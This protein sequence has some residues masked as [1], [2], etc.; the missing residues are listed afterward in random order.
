ML[1][2]LS[3]TTSKGGK[4]LFKGVERDHHSDII[5]IETL[6]K[7]VLNRSIKLRSTTS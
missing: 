5:Q 1:F 2:K 4:L 6:K 7:C 3:S